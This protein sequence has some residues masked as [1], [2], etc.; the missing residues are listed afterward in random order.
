MPVGSTAGCSGQDREAKFR[1]PPETPA[2]QARLRF[3][4]WLA[5]IETR[6]TNIRASHE[7]KTLGLPPKEARALAGEWYRWFI[8][9]HEAKTTDPEYWS[10]VIDLLIGE[11]EDI[12]PEVMN[13]QGLN[14]DLTALVKDDAGVIGPYIADSASTALFLASRGM[15]LTSEAYGLFIGYLGPDYVNAIFVLH[16]RAKG[17]WSPD[18]HPRQFPK[19]DRGTEAVRPWS[20]FEKWVGE[21]KPAGTTVR[22]WRVVLLEIDAKWPDANAISEDAAR[23]WV[24]GLVNGDRSRPHG[25]GNV[26]EFG[27]QNFPLRRYEQ[28]LIRSNPFAKVKVEVP[29]RKKLREKAFTTGEA[30]IILR[31]SLAT[32]WHDSLIAGAR[33][34]VPWL[35]AYRRGEG[36]RDHTTAWPG[37]STS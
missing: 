10:L 8:A 33:R 35:C 32:N 37:H 21:R 22:R 12:D 9:R 28:K 7:G 4:E 2:L 23:A 1:L 17:D 16:Q 20:L 5:E 30:E 31:A 15:V 3:T 29:K 36:R 27:E 26:A 25:A 14:V 34:W 18:E 11:L 6:I 24:R 13:S 19:F